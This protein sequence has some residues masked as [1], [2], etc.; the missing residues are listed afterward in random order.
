MAINLSKGQRVSLDKG[1][2]LA[3]VGLGWDTNRYDGAADFDLDASAFMLGANGK[4]R[5]DEDFIFYGNLQ[6]ADGAVTHTGDSLE[7]GSGGDEPGGDEP[8]GDDKPKATLEDWLGNWKYDNTF[9]VLLTEADGK[10]YLNWKDDNGVYVQVPFTFDAET[11]NLLLYMPQYRGLG[12]NQEVAYYLNLYTPEN[13]RLSPDPA[14]GS[15]ILTA[16]LDEGGESASFT[17]A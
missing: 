17:A 10:V 3:L 11:G 8:G 1:V 5:K 15:L 16:S 6:S 4:V 7:G 2:R 12:G 13:K 9:D 14:D